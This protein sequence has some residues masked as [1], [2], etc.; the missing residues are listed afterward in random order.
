MKK[1]LFVTFIL[2][3]LLITCP[4]MAQKKKETTKEPEKKEAGLTSS[5]FGGLSFRSI[6]PAWCSGRISDFAVNPLNHS[7]I[8]VGVSAG[9]IWKTTNNGTTWSPIFDKYGAYAIGCLK[10]DPENPSVIWAGTGENTHQRQL[11]YGDG[12]YKSEDGG[13]S[14]KN[15]GLKESRQIGMIEIDPR[16]TDIV[17]VAA[18]GSIWAPGGERG[19]YKTTDGGKTW[20]KVLDV[21]EN[22]GINNV[23]MD[24]RNPDVLYATSEQRRR[25]IY[26]KIG[27]GPESAV[28]KSKDAGKTWDKI[29]SGLPSGHIGGMGI[30]ISPVNPD[31]IYLIMEAAGE[32]SGFYRTTNRGAS[33]EKMSSYASSGQ[34]YNEIYCDPKDVDKVY[35][36]ETTSKVTLDGGKTWNNVGNN[37]RHVDDHALW[38]DPSDTKHLYIGGDGGVYETFDEGKNFIFKSN[39]PV[40]Q[41]YRVAVDNAFPFYNVYGGTQ[42]N[43]SMGG[44]SRNIN[45]DGVVNADW[46]VTVG[47]DGFWVAI[48]PVDENIVY[49]ES[50]YGNAALWDKK[51]EESVSIRPVPR[52]GEKTYRWFWDTP[53]VISPHQR[54]R[55]YMAA[56]KVFRSDNRGRSWEVI[57]EDI[58]RNE[59]RN[60]FK[61]MGKYWSVDAV[62]KDVSTSLWGLVVALAESKVKKDLL[63]AGTDDGVIA[64]T[65]DGGKNWTRVTT[66]PGIPEYT[67]VSDILPDKFNENI[68]YASFNNMM[69]DDFKPY[70][71]KSSDKGKT[72]TAITNKLPANGTI[73]TIEQDNVN[74]NLLFAGSEFGFYFSADGGNE[75][76][77]F[78]S[79]LPTIA[80]RDIALQERESDLVLGTFGRGFYVLDDYTPIRNY[81]KEILDKD[82]YIF[83]VSDAKMYIQSSG[84]DNQGSTYFKSPNPEFGA[85]FTYFVKEVPKTA[86]AIRQE[87]EKA[88]FEKG[89]PIPQPSIAELDAESKE[90]KPYL[91]FTITDESNNI[92]KRIYKS[93]SKGVS[94]TTWNFTYESN[95]PVTTTKFEPVP[96]GG[97]RRGGGGIQAMPG[98]YKVSM[99]MVAKGETKELSGPVPFVCKPLNLATF[100][101]TDLKG[102]YAWIK[103][104]SEFSRTMYGTISYTGELTNKVNAMMQAIHQTPSAPAGLMKEA[105]RI[106]KELNDIQ[107]IFSGPQAKASQ[108]E[109]PPVDMALSDRLSEMANASYGTSGDISIIAKEQL[110]ILKAE[111]PPILARVKK[112]G[113]DL[114]K[115]DKELDAV[116]APWTPGRVPAL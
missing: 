53:I 9:N 105:E 58:T 47:G 43:N 11:G 84:F 52:K 104:A 6:G 4:G 111:F 10:M 2:G 92:V 61:V 90:T 35:S 45:R 75:W 110:D 24:P 95:S 34:Y 108:E 13:A 44:P 60:Q 63:Y 56:N 66:F 57:S 31:V 86:K 23:V 7:E 74:P 109:I 83:P 29:M 102:K 21:S 82:G 22:T 96:S 12:I 99:S 76:I 115:L 36:M 30:A 97:G 94:R 5:T 17:Y 3:F 55:I 69:S 8:Y 50:Q 54:E 79:G 67:F 103:E 68:V 65:E 48:D 113:D 89:E 64:V 80:V 26:T 49:T 18:E 27:G 93:A 107:F 59:D 87:K 51:S 25:H 1:N 42:D 15:M 114:L 32:S 14:W 106:N 91:I 77:E 101:A 20:T 41:F 100:T 85:T 19:L 81:K 70:I 71:L 39:L 73:H 16:N 46:K 98:T 40:T 88:L 116:K 62:A 78:K 33:W 38:I 112:A 72:W 28:Y 37:G